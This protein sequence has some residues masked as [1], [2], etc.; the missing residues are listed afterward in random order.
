MEDN[1]ERSLTI[2]HEDSKPPKK[3]LKLKNPFKRNKP[4]VVE[5]DD[6]KPKKEPKEK[7]EK[8]K[9]VKE[10][11]EPKEKKEKVKGKKECL[12]CGT[13]FKAKLTSCPKCGSTNTKEYVDPMKKRKRKKRAKK[14]LNFF[15]GLLML[16]G[17]AVMLAML[18]F[19][20]Y[21]VMSAPSFNTDLLYRKEATILYDKNGNEITK[22]GLEQRILVSYDD[23][24]EVLIDAI[25]ATEDARYFQHN[26][27]DVVRFTKASLGQVVGQA[28]AGGASTLTMQVVKNTF[29][30][31]EAH[32]FK[33]IVRKFTDI[34]MAVFK[35]EKNYTK[36]EIMEF[37]VNAPFLGSHTYGVEQACQTY[38]GKSVRDISLPEAALI[39][40]IFNAPTTYSPFNSLELATQR[41]ATVLNLMVRHGYITKEQADE[42]NAIPV[43][44]LLIDPSPDKIHKYQS[45]IDAT[46]DDVTKKTGMNPYDVPML[47]YTTLDPNIQ[48]ILNQ[49]NDGSLGYKWV[50]DYIDIGLAITDV[51]TGAVTALDGGRNVST[52]RGFNR[53]TMGRFQPGS[54]IKPIMDYGPYIEYNNGSPGTIFYDVPYSYSTGQK[55]TNSDNSYKGAMTM[56]TA[57]VESR[58]VPAVQ[59]FHAVDKD[60]VAEFAH[61]CGLDY[62]DTL[63]ESYAIGGGMEVSPLTMAAAYGTFARGG[64]YIEPYTFTKII[65]QQTDEVIEH[66]VEKTQ[67][68]SR[69]TAYMINDMLVSATK[70]G[71]GGN[72]RVGGDV[73]SKTGTSTYSYAAMRSYGIPDSASSDNWV[74]TYSPDYVISFR[75]GYDELSHDHWTNAIKAAIERKKISALLANRIFTSGARFAKPDTVIS[76]KY[77]KESIPAELPSEYTPAELIGT[78][79]FKKG[80]EPS[81]ISTRF[82]QLNNPSGVS[83]SENNGIVTLKW[84][85]IEVPNAINQTYLQNYFKDAYGSHAETF[86]KRRI[87]YNDEHIGAIGYQV[88]L[89]TANGEE[90]LGFTTNTS[91]NYNAALN[92][93]YTFIVRS[94]Y[95]IYKANQSSGIEVTTTV[96]GAAEPDPEPDEPDPEEPDPEEPDPEEPDPLED[97]G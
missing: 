53:A 50:D 92:G 66:K 79:L 40:G 85:A 58:N 16:A 39:A 81:Q 9:K 34:Y 54:I 41:R 45:F 43:E 86:L 4:I 70:A 10:P 82:A 7:K 1:E 44:S 21:I 90:D 88:Y 52:K 5:G 72:I 60:K 36:E 49:L 18:A 23:L 37:Y 76:S 46:I 42:A 62:G 29:T 6:E 30:S 61:A 31:K 77:E 68:M 32:G 13:K 65:I 11:K 55:I 2:I 69:E 14:I 93:Q 63:Y 15:L 17:I 73:A 56:R 89:R 78:E 67:A 3:K 87:T 57:L 74:I 48:D 80:T 94:A 38:F 22:I 27:F 84:N 35:I 83:G 33:G 28:G 25:V 12:E 64:Y 91:F 59:A 71:V 97:E 20:G 95:S 26:G 8:V 24:P 96:T 75:Y 51:H 19:C 47:I